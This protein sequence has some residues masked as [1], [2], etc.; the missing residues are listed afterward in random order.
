MKNHTA[1]EPKSPEAIA[2]RST[3]EDILKQGGRTL[4]QAAVENEVAEYIQRYEGI[5]DEQKHQLV[6]RNGS[7]PERDILTGLG[8]ITV[9][10]PRIDDRKLRQRG[11]EGFSSSILPRYLRRIPNI[12]NLVPALYLKGISTGDIS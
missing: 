7:F 10:Q 6:V 4:L 9:K 3:L 8:P 1:T 11:E 2:T 5:I 12:D